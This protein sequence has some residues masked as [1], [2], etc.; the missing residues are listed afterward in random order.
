[1]TSGGFALPGLEDRFKSL[2]G[3]L[4][5][6]QEHYIGSVIKSVLFIPVHGWPGIT[7]QILTRERLVID[8][9]IASSDLGPNGDGE[10]PVRLTVDELMSIRL[11]GERIQRLLAHK[12]QPLS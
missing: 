1:L 2:K 9:H 4:T 8:A 6:N 5:D 12:V 10:F 3:L 11:C 7:L